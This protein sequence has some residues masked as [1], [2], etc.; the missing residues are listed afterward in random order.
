MLFY[1]YY[2]ALQV[3]THS[4]D[5]VLASPDKRERTASPVDHSTSMHASTE[6]LL[7]DNDLNENEETPASKEEGEMTSLSKQSVSST[8]GPS[9]STVGSS[10][11]VQPKQ[12]PSAGNPPSEDSPS[13]RSTIPAGHSSTL[14]FP[15]PKRPLSTAADNSIEG[16]LIYDR[17]PATLQRSAKPP[18]GS[19]K[20]LCGFV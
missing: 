7:D 15:L 16:D 10:P 18:A 8:P 3:T 1:C 20:V 4:E 6:Q 19:A 14:L 13:Y 17:L 9:S 5:S 2:Y 12:V 11:S